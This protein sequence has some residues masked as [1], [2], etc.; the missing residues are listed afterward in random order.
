MKTKNILISLICALIFPIS[1]FALSAPVISPVPGKVDAK[2]YILTITVPI[3]SKV[4]IVGGSSDIAP[5]TDG[6][7]TDKL[8]GV[9][10]VTVGLVQERENVFSIV[11]EKDGETSSS[12]I[13]TI[14]ETSSGKT[15]TGDQTPPTAPVIDPIQNPVTTTT[16]TITGSSEALANIYVENT[17]GERVGSTSANSNGLFHVDVNLLA[18]KTNRFNV[19]AE[20][21]AYNMGPATQVVIQAVGTGT[22][23]QSATGATTTTNCPFTDVIGHWAQQY[24]CELYQ[25]GMVNGTTS[26]TFNPD[27]HITRAELVKIAVKVFGFEVPASVAE[28]PFPDVPKDAWYAPYVKVAKDN[29]IIG[30][31]PDGYF[32]PSQNVDRASA[33]KILVV[34]SGLDYAGSTANFTDVMQDDWFA[35]Y[36]GF[37][38]ENGIVGGY[39]D[40]AFRPGDYVTRAEAVKMAVKLLDLKQANP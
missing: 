30:G 10:K 11:A 32:Y 23:Q 34:A 15:G 37:A 14:N 2:T 26:T 4:T 17:D 8:D 18:N 5:V 22:A 19:Y 6:S 3:G 13:V 24:I 20:D 27:A 29:G 38:Q 35:E 39:G 25:K 1:V 33:L 36:V 9:V 7:G 16:Y 12:T 21:A 40:G 28:D 31:Y